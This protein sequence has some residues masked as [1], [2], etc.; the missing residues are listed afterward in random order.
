MMVVM[1]M[2]MMKVLLLVVKVGRQ[3]RRRR[4]R[5]LQLLLLR[6]RL[7]PRISN[8]AAATAAALDARISNIGR[9]KERLV[10]Q[11]SW[12]ALCNLTVWIKQHNATGQT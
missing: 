5:F 11:E 2:V 1:V 3:G 10:D 4:Q 9:R 6:V 7:R 8:D 12:V